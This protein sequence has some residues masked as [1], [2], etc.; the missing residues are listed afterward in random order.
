MHA[1]N[2]RLARDVAACVTHQVP[3]VI[4]SLRAPDDVVRPIHGYGGVVFHDVTTVRHA[5]KALEAEWADFHREH[6]IERA[7]HH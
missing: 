5:E 1:S 3:I 6:G 2:D 4:T 7:S